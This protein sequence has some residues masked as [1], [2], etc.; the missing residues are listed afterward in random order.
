MYYNIMTGVSA[1]EENI[2][3][4]VRVLSTILTVD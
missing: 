3:D 2:R 1:S 4:H